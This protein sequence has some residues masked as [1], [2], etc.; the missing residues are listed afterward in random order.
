MS[1]AGSIFSKDTL[2]DYNTFTVE[3]IVNKIYEEFKTREWKGKILKLPEGEYTKNNL[4]PKEEIKKII[5]TSMDKRLIKGNRL[6]EKNRQKI[7]QA[8][9]TLLRKKGKTVINIRKANRPETLSSLDM[10]KETIAVGN[11]RERSAVFYSSNLNEELDSDKL[12]ILLDL[13]N[14]NEESLGLKYNLIEANEFL[15]KTPLDLVFVSHDPEFKFLKQ[16]IKKEN[17]EKIDAWIKSRDQGFYN[18][19]YSFTTVGG[20]HSKQLSFNPDFFI[21][22]VQDG[23]EYIIVVEIKADDDNSD[24]NKAKLRWT[25]QHFINL[26]RELE[27]AGINQRYIFH[28][29]SPNS[30]SEFFEYL[31]DGRL[32]KGVFRSDLE[33]K[34]EANGRGINNNIPVL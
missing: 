20:K 31:R 19:E 25:R 22:I 34:L 15:F 4:P 27:D 29:L 7:L 21:K 28:F 14:I 1:L 32:I 13:I 2:I 12:N 11:L 24:E 5:R 3:E 30:Y 23:F 16:L 18:V 26:N 33:D 17:A 8:F 6:V 10:D 9:G